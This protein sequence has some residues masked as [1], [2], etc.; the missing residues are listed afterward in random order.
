MEK[1]EASPFPLLVETPRANLSKGMR[2]INGIYTQQFN[3]Y[4]RKV[5]HVLQG[6]YKGIIVDKDNYLLELSR[7]IVLNPVRARK[8]KQAGDY[9]WSSYRATVGMAKKPDFLDC[10]LILQ[11]FSED[12]SVARKRYKEFVSD[13]IAGAKK[14][15]DE[16]M[17]Q[18]YLGDKIFINSISELVEGKMYAKEIPKIQRNIISPK[19]EEL[20]SDITKT[21]RKE[22]NKKI[23]KAHME[24]G[25]TQ[26]EISN[27]L[28]LH[29]A[30]LS[31]LIKN[32]YE[33]C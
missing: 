6:R 21:D 32:Q 7:Y 2:H 20:F 18:I 12:L 29:Y 5:G 10:K 24:Y 17:G 16:V 22:R 1:C 11:Q 15:W 26:K 14:P 19:L 3:R 28:G 13:K 31:R 4:H 9:K 8:V 33:K 30:S 25:Y 27:Y 23:I